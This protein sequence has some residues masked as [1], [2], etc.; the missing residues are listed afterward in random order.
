MDV[1]EDNV[2]TI[3]NL[4]ILEKKEFL[5]YE[6]KKLV[7]VDNPNDAEILFVWDRHKN[8]NALEW[9][10]NIFLSFKK[11]DEEWYVIHHDKGI[12]PQKSDSIICRK[13]MH[14]KKNFLYY[15][16]VAILLDDEDRKK[17]RII[18]EI[19][20]PPLESVFK[21]LNECSIPNNHDASFIQAKEK[22]YSI[23]DEIKS[24]VKEF[25]INKYSGKTRLDE[26]E[27][28]LSDFKDKLLKEVNFFID[29]FR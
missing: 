5:K 23:N 6:N 8:A 7:E 14:S 11:D 3:G 28:D 25:L 13:G 29:N 26:Y 22:L 12:K 15:T 10:S 4:D 17:E 18:K 16:V 19:F 27:T 1:D 21:F 20:V 2:M 9:W 24:L